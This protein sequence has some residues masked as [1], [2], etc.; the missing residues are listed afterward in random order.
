MAQFFPRPLGLPLLLLST[1]FSGCAHLVKITYK[2]DAL[3]HP[4]FDQPTILWQGERVQLVDHWRDG[5]VTWHPR[6]V[7]KLLWYSDIPNTPRNVRIAHDWLMSIVTVIE[8]G[9][10]GTTNIENRRSKLGS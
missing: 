8:T 3:I 5:S 1:L 6:V 10:E 9:V 2:P 7:Q 4:A